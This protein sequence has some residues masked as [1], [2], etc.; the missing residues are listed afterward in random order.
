MN[1][2]NEV[3]R[4]NKQNGELF[5]KY[6][7]PYDEEFDADLWAKVRDNIVRPNNMRILELLKE[8]AREIKAEDMEI[9]N[10][11]IRHIEVFEEINTPGFVVDDNKTYPVFPCGIDE[12]LEKYKGVGK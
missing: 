4:L 12:F 5:D 3:A 7:L 8:V 2:F 6:G 11:W 1:K 9:Y 10:L